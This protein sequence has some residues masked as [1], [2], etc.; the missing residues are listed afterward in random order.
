MAA[1][2]A[3]ANQRLD[4]IHEVQKSICEVQL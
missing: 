3:V 2:L 1:A 4:L